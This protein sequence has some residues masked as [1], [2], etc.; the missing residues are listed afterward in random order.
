MIVVTCERF[1]RTILERINGRCD[2]GD[3]E[4]LQTHLDSCQSCREF[5]ELSW[6]M[7]RSMTLKAVTSEPSPAADTKTVS[8]LLSKRF[9]FSASASGRS[10]FSPLA[11]DHTDWVRGSLA[12]CAV[13]ILVAALP[14]VF[15]AAAANPFEHIRRHEA[16]FATAIAVG[17]FSVALKPHRAMGLVPITSTLTILMF[18]GAAID[19]ASGG[20]NFL[21][22]AIHVVEFVGLACIWWLS[23]GW[24][25]L[26][27]KR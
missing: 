16:T 8:S 24:V 2:S 7:H 22:E 18:I 17:M 20:T 27:R 23:G 15:S 5:D 13:L 11:Q 12:T 1:E 14:I 9:R 10:W 3:I 6:N 4:I 26:K 21:N 19:L 25:R